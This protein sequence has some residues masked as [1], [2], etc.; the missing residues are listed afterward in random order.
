MISL[1]KTNK[2]KQKKNLNHLSC[3]KYFFSALKI[4]F[5]NLPSNNEDVIQNIDCLKQLILIF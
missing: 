1:I 4:Y 3:H 5:L 2:Q